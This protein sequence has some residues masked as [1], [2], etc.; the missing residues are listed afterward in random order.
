[1]HLELVPYLHTLGIQLLIKIMNTLLLLSWGKK[2]LSYR[3]STAFPPFHVSRYEEL[4][5]FLF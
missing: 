2:C 5:P 4:D 3:S 1:M